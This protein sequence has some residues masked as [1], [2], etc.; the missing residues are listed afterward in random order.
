M[1][2]LLLP[3]NTLIPVAAVAAAAAAA[4]PA[5]R[6]RPTPPPARAA[7]PLFDRLYDS[8]MRGKKLR[9]RLSSHAAFTKAHG[10]TFRPAILSGIGG[11]VDATVHQKGDLVWEETFPEEM[12]LGMK[13][14]SN[15]RIQG[16]AAESPVE[17]RGIQVGDLIVSIG[18]GV[19]VGGTE[20]GLKG[21]TLK[22]FSAAMPQAQWPLT[23]RFKRPAPPKDI[24]KGRAGSVYAR[25]Y[26]RGV[27]RLQ[28]I[29]DRHKTRPRPTFQP[30][31][32]SKLNGTSNVKPSRP[33]GGGGDFSTRLYK[34]ARERQQRRLKRAAETRPA[35]CTFQ[36]ATNGGG[37]DKAEHVGGKS[38]HDRLYSR[39]MKKKERKKAAAAASRQRGKSGGEGQ[40]K[41]TNGG[42]DGGD[43]IAGLKRLFSLLDTDK[44]GRI[45]Y[46]ELLAGVQEPTA[47]KL[48]AASEKLRPLL[49]PSHVK[50]TMEA[51][52]GLNSE[53]NELD[54]KAL[55]AFAGEV[56]KA[57]AG[58]KKTP[59]QDS[60]STVGTHRLYEDGAKRR[61]RMEERRRK[62]AA[63]LT[64][65]PKLATSRKNTKHA[66]HAKAVIQTKMAAVPPDPS[67][68]ETFEV[69]ATDD[70]AAAA[71]AAAANAAMQDAK[72]KRKQNRSPLHVQMSPAERRKRNEKLMEAQLAK[73]CTFSPKINARSSKKA[74]GKVSDRL[75]S[76]AV[77]RAERFRQIEA[78]LK[79]QP[80][81][82]LPGKRRSPP[83]DDGDKMS[84]PNWRSEDLYRR[85][86]E[87][88]SRRDERAKAG[89]PEQCTFSPQTNVTKRGSAPHI[90]PIDYTNQLYERGKEQLAAKDIKFA[91]KFHAAEGGSS[92]MSPSSAASV[93]PSMRRNGAGELSQ[94]RQYLPGGAV[95]RPPKSVPQPMIPGY[96]S[97]VTQAREDSASEQP[98]QQ[99]QQQEIA[100]REERM[101]IREQEMQRRERGQK[102]DQKIVLRQER[103]DEQ[104]ALLQRQRNG[105]NARAGAEGVLGGWN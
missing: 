10:L 5:K 58:G 54:L 98:P 42:T 69:G 72:A 73:D 95:W 77:E 60:S 46:K 84:N 101:A 4:P 32:T 18:W 22:D 89:T 23:I 6:P 92:S 29:E 44:D 39:G 15:L 62:A 61:K 78:D 19:Q 33:G 91:R 17:R 66:N 36:P 53:T 47:K 88:Q 2:Q 86:L 41:R 40:A 21:K 103:L 55:L 11:D 50:E 64:F 96:D 57:A 74:V 85:G 76:N 97:P 13:L 26:A 37:Q 100:A 45:T 68:P 9:D 27:K 1:E 104:R 8:G 99:E 82:K 65:R 90:S 12:S 34:Q 30:I 102:I 56:A 71:A 87:Q 52:M 70:P 3:L 24:D 105:V 80:P 20:I 81:P 48:V 75:Y 59:L 93:P 25:L 14:A 51:I 43:Q 49:K 35:E 94:P 79:P 63:E 7:S 28:Q 16:F 31:T 83:R 67:S 38:I